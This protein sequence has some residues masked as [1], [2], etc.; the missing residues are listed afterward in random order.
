MHI[1]FAI[2]YNLSGINERS[3]DEFQNSLVSPISV[4]VNQKPLLQL[5]Y[6]LSDSASYTLLDVNKVKEYVL[7]L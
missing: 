5:I 7:P 1:L 4:I 3:K 6:C 2:L